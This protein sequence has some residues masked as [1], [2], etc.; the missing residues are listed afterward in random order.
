MQYI[1]QLLPYVGFICYVWFGLTIIK[2]SSLTLDEK[3]FLIISV[4]GNA[5]YMYLF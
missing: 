4:I 2:Q 3:A 1:K 5:F